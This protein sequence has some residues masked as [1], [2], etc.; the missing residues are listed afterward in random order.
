MSGDERGGAGAGAGSVYIV[1]LGIK[2]G[3]F[4]R[5]EGVSSVGDFGCGL[6]GY[7]MNLKRLGFGV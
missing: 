3:E 2:L 5:K 1:E 7:G 6:C 4:Y